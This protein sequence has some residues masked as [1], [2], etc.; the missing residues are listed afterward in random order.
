MD[1]VKVTFPDGTA[2]EYPR[3][4]TVLDVA[5]SLG[6]RLAD[7][8]I[9]GKMNGD[10]VELGR[11]ID[12][13][14]TLRILTA[15]DPEAMEVYRHSSAHLL[16]AAVLELFPETKLG[17]GP[18]LDNG[19][20]YD[21]QRPTPFSEDDLAKIEKKMKELAEKDLPYEHVYLPKEQGLKKF[22]AMGEHMKCQLITEKTEGEDKI[23][24]YTLGPHFLD[25]CRGPHVPSSSKIKAFK[26]LSIA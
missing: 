15:R 24:V 3:G 22:E 12:H 8:A 7:A 25:F 16:A 10:R 4:T 13:D 5:R 2:R 19:F 11:P 20:Y 23:S 14:T 9:V 18:P 26:L 6:S 17:I 21:F 1:N